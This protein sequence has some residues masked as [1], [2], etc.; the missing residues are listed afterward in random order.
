VL[1]ISSSLIGLS[2]FGFTLSEKSAFN[3]IDVVN[4]DFATARG[5]FFEKKNEFLHLCQQKSHKQRQGQ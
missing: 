3:C 2:L 1:A 4:E 5:H